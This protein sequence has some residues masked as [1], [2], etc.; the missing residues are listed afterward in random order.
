MTVSWR[1]VAQAPKTAKVTETS[2]GE[3]RGL[4]FLR[5][6]NPDIPSVDREKFLEASTG[7]FSESVS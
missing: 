4:A 3:G 1:V 6:E 5:R 2:G 7:C